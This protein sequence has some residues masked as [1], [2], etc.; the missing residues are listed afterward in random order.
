MRKRRILRKE[1]EDGREEFSGKNGKTEE[2]NSSE[3]TETRKKDFRE[4]SS[5]P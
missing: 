1:R 4:E 5:N 2:K 3:R